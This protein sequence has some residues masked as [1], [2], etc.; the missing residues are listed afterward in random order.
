MG[1][2]DLCSSSYRHVGL[3]L[4]RNPSR[5]GAGLSSRLEIEIGDFRN[6]NVGSFKLQVL[7]QLDS[8]RKNILSYSS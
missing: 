7:I 5:E 8:G 2:D 1:D 4:L 6:E 3:Q